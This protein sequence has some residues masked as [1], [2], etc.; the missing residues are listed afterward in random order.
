MDLS[1][2]DLRVINSDTP[3]YL[4]VYRYYWDQAGAW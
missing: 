1:T 2:A 3:V 4:G